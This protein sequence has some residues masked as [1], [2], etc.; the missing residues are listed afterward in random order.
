MR[1]DEV[2]ATVR[3]HGIELT[4]MLDVDWPT[5]FREIGKRLNVNDRTIAYRMEDLGIYRKYI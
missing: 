4:P 3:A 5:I 1:A 2:I